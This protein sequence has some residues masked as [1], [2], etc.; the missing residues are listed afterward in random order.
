[1]SNIN[2]LYKESGIKPGGG[3]NG[4]FKD[5]PKQPG[6]KNKNSIAV[7]LIIAAVIVIAGFFLF[8]SGRFNSPKEVR[9]VAVM[10][11]PLAFFIRFFIRLFNRLIN[12]MND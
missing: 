9:V 2:D 5:N 7:S 8:E 11:V 10:I 3:F 12:K 1:M 4:N 6:G